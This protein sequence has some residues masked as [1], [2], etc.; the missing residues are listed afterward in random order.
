MQV[1]LGKVLTDESREEELIF[2]QM[3]N[4]GFQPFCI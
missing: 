1:D 4:I 2:A 3:Y